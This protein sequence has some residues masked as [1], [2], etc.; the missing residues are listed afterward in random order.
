MDFGIPKIEKRNSQA[1]N[2]PL[3]IVYVSYYQL[4]TNPR[5]GRLIAA[6]F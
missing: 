3:S 2:G 5:V 1:L 4:I 6:L